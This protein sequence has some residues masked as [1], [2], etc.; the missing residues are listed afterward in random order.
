MSYCRAKI[1]IL[2]SQASGEA[3]DKV[4]HDNQLTQ[5]FMTEM[6]SCFCKIVQGTGRT[7]GVDCGHAVAKGGAKQA[8]WLR[9]G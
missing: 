4:D 6:E 9:N 2:S 1:S 8:K 7:S 3:A 5:N